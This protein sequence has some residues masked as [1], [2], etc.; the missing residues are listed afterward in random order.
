[1]ATPHAPLTLWLTDRSRYETGLGRCPR[2]R[3]LAYHAGPY[4]YGLQLR[5]QSMPQA[6][7]TGV[8]HATAILDAILLHQD[9]LPTLEE[10]RQA[11]DTA[12]TGY[13]REAE[14]RGFR[15]ALGSEQTD[16]ILAEQSC[17]IEGFVWL[18]ARRF[19]PWL[20]QHY[21]VLSVE[22]ERIQILSCTCGAG[23]LPVADHLVRECQGVA[24]MS[25]NDLLAQ[26]R[27][28]RHLAYFEK[29]TD[30]RDSSLW[31]EQ[32]ETKPQLALGTLDAQARFGAEVT[33]L[34][35]VGLIKGS[36]RADREGEP[37]RQQSALCYGYCRE[38]NPPLA[39][40]DWLPSYQWAEPDGT[41][42][43]APRTYE[44]RGLW[45]LSEA[46]PYYRAKKGQDPHVTPL[47]VW[48]EFL[49]ESVSSKSLQLLGPLNRQDDQLQSLV[50]SMV[51]EEERWRD[52]LWQYY[53]GDG[54]PLLQ[55]QLF[56][57]SWDCRRFGKE[58]QCQF[59]PI[60]FK[61]PGWEDPLAGSYVPRRPHHE[62]EVEQMKA[63]GL[64][65]EQGQEEGE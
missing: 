42:R 41:I 2:E 28:G 25:R 55:D 16:E 43:R 27:R 39:A 4:G 52:R 36:R 47:E 44:R 33:E 19:L 18:Y 21:R 29:K 9:R 20:H 35:I 34:Y 48:T 50:R 8:H 37:K 22:E 45:Y 14:A 51:A 64:D 31:A 46:W 61:A 62:P 3:Q 12:I 24:L 17:L 26:H 10:T 58:H 53:Q 15:G 40:E 63:R 65:P 57:Q 59:V 7:G 32:W 38:E 6:T 30:G 13:L 54:T 49:P 23:P 11:V 60:C 5:A 56:P 1:M